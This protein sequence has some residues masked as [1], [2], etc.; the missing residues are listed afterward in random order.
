MPLETRTTP[1]GCAGRAA[2]RDVVILVEP[3]IGRA[4][5]HGSGLERVGPGAL[6]AGSIETAR[7]A[8]TASRGVP[9]ARQCAQGRVGRESRHIVY[10]PESQPLLSATTSGSPDAGRSRP[11]HATS[12]RRRGTITGPH[13]S[14]FQ[15]RPVPYSSPR[16]GAWG[17][18]LV[19][20][21]AGKS[22]SGFGESRGKGVLAA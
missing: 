22:S 13:H 10:H 17:T 21:V 19:P 12:W 18:W 11:R 3:L 7:C 4:G 2:Y 5:R 6:R 8:K 20:A 9:F 16:D 14:R 15:T 1:A